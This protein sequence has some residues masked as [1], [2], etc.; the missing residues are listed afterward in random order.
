MGSAGL[1]RAHS[2]SGFRPEGQ[3]SHVW[4]SVPPSTGL[5]LLSMPLMLQSARLA[6]LRGGLRTACQ[7]GRE[8]RQTTSSG[9][10]CETSQV[11]LLLY[12]LGQDK[13]QDPVQNQGTE[14]SS[15]PL[16]SRSIEV[17]GR[18]GAHVPGREGHTVVGLPQGIPKPYA[19]MHIFAKVSFTF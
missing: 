7:E 10:G 18:E 13:S 6:F 3:L 5:P 9:V 1:R 17:I 2:S 8:R 4:Q 11:S 15:L 16:D 12:S 14:Q 19:A